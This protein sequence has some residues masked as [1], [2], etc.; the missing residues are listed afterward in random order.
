VPRP[1]SAPLRVGGQALPDGVLM[2]AGQ[3][4][5][6]ARAD[7]RIETGTLPRQPFADVPL[8]RV[9]TGLVPAVVRGLRSMRVRRAGRPVPLRVRW[10]LPLFLLVPF[11]IDFLLGRLV[12]TSGSV[13]WQVAG[14][15]FVAIALQLAALRLVLPA[16]MWRYHGAEHKAVG[17]YEAGVD[18]TDVHAVMGFSRVHPRCG[19]NVVA[20]LLLFAL[21]PFQANIGLTVVLW[22]LMLA[23]AVELVSGAAKTPLRPVSRLVL[24]G[25][26]LLQRYVTTSEPTYAEQAVACRALGACLAALPAHVPAQRTAEPVAATPT[27]A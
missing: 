25:G 15:S 6:V 21:V 2:R 14:R 5:A 18:V 19:T 12:P 8:L 9:V 22:V 3:V 27:A 17:A 16:A 24:G 20:V 1:A 4:W 7:G 11:A 26:R 10:S 13:A 23:G